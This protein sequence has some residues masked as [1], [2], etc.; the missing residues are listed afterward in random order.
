M[1]Y[2]SILYLESTIW[3]GITSIIIN[4]LI[5]APCTPQGRRPRRASAPKPSSVVIAGTRQHHSCSS[6]A[7]IVHFVYICHLTFICLRH[8][9]SVLCSRL[10]GTC[11]MGTV[12]TERALFIQYNISSEEALLVLFRE[13]SWF[14]CIACSPRWRELTHEG[15]DVVRASG[16]LLGWKKVGAPCRFLFANWDHHCCDVLMSS[17]LLYSR[18]KWHTHRG[19]SWTVLNTVLFR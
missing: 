16:G 12:H 17:W 4:P 3:A 9:L 6:L 18:F 19:F 8:R 10:L 15:S 2:S 11:K 13:R 7:I 1:E 5:L 14:M